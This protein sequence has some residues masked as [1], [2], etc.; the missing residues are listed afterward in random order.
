MKKVKINKTKNL[1]NS[2]KLSTFAPVLETRRDGRGVDSGG[3]ESRWTERVRGFESLS[4]RK[5]KSMVKAEDVSSAFFV[6]SVTDF[7][8][9]RCRT[10][11]GSAGKDERSDVNS[12]NTSPTK[13]LRYNSD[14]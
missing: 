5:P 10:A 3:L 4:F 12:E 13:I 11:R 2:N 1:H 7:T 6:R 9:A 14:H 8:T